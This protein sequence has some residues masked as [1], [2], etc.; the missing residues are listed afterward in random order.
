MPGVA[1]VLTYKNLPKS[2]PMRPTGE[3]LAQLREEVNFQGQLIAVVAA[4]TED[5]AKDAIEAIE[6][7]L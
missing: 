2:Y 4:E 3:S 5:L 7:E 1:H 6:I